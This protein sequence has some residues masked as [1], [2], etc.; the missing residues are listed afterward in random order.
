MKNF[1]LFAV[2]LTTAIFT[3]CS[4]DDPGTIITHHYSATMRVTVFQLV[5]NYGSYTDSVL[6]GAKVDLYE[7]KDNRENVLPP[8][9]SKITGLS[10][11]VQFDNLDTNYYYLRVTNPQTQEVMKDETSTPEGK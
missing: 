2:I 10:G 3:S 8:D 11:M 9:Y 7:K 5:N 1:F 6:A 4:K